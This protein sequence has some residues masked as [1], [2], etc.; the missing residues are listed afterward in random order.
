MLKDGQRRCWVG[1]PQDIN[2]FELLHSI[3]L[4]VRIP[5]IQVYSPAKV[6]FARADRFSALLLVCI[7]LNTVSAV[8]RT[9]QH[10]SDS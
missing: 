10:L 8:G 9:V 5:V 7:L 3:L 6:F 2:L 4:P 1:R